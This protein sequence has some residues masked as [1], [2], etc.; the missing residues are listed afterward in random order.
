MEQFQTNKR[1]SMQVAI[2]L[3]S[4]LA[5]SACG[6]SKMG[7]KGGNANQPVRTGTNG[8]VVNGAG[9]Q[10]PQSILPT[11]NL[12][13]QQM[14]GQ[15]GTAPQ[16]LQQTAAEIQ[17]EIDRAREDQERLG[18]DGGA[19]RTSGTSYVVVGNPC[20]VPCVPAGQVVVANPSVVC[21]TCVS[22]TEQVQRPT[23]QRTV[24]QVPV[25]TVPRPSGSITVDTNTGTVVTGVT[26]NVIC[27][28]PC[29]AQRRAAAV[30]AA[31]ASASAGAST[32][33]RIVAGNVI[34]QPGP[35]DTPVVVEVGT[36]E[37]V[38]GITETHTERVAQATTPTGRTVTVTQCTETT[39]SIEGTQVCPVVNGT[40]GGS[41]LVGGSDVGRIVDRAA[42]GSDSAS[43]GNEEAGKTKDTQ[44]AESDA[45]LAYLNTYSSLLVP[46]SNAML[47]EPAKDTC[48]VVGRIG[49]N[50][51]RRTKPNNTITLTDDRDSNSVLLVCNLNEGGKYVIRRRPVNVSGS[52]S[53]SLLDRME[54]QISL[55]F[56]TSLGRVGNIEKAEALINDKHMCTENK[57]YTSSRRLDIAF[58]PLVNKTDE[59]EPENV[60]KAFLAHTNIGMTGFLVSN[61]KENCLRMSLT[62]GRGQL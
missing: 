50:I 39:V 9:Q 26:G 33:T 22:V 54:N 41:V 11:G 51:P 40:A 56:V 27:D 48:D 57:N 34:V 19:T 13:G 32:G 61:R 38:A 1:K 3:V 29:Q 45:S 24:V 60:F 37:R 35:R 25:V 44:V 31:A 46:G 30:A 36:G 55:V 28:N 58:N 42:E 17:R 53:F 21:T 20:V 16:T 18:R 62:D 14:Q 4:V 43:D 7:K 6:K 47:F 8:E 10:Q 59:G 23:V 12:Q 5:L 49:A 2:L 15:Q 52:F